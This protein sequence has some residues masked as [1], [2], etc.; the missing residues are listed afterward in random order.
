M[1][2]F[3]AIVLLSEKRRGAPRYPTLYETTFFQKNQGFW[4]EQRVSGKNNEF[5]VQKSF[6]FA[7]IQLFLVQGVERKGKVIL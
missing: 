6:F 1:F 4:H 3:H 5:L 7:E 2:V